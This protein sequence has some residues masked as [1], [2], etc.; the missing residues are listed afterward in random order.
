[1]E[2]LSMTTIVKNHRRQAR[3]V[4]P[5]KTKV[6]STVTWDYKGQYLFETDVGNFIWNDPFH[7]GDGVIRPFH[8]SYKDWLH[9]KNLPHGRYKGEH[10]VDE[11]CV[12]A[13]FNSAPYVF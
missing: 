7:G 11:F 2:H 8:G 5:T 12:G 10:M 4:D 3:V 13:V 1:M 9:Y 6:D